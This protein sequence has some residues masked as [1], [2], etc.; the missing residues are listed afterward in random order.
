M[1]TDTLTVPS[2]RETLADISYD[3]RYYEGDFRSMA[4]KN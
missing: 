2:Q 1:L 3:R 4:T